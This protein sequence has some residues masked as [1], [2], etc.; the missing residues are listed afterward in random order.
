M[1][2]GCRRAASKARD[3]AKLTS[4]CV[5][6]VRSIEMTST[7]DIFAT[8]IRCNEQKYIPLQTI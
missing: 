6:S 5:N 8:R 3:S 2:G 1:N 4:C 7:F